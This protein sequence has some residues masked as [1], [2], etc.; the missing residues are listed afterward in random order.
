MPDVFQSS[1]E[2]PNVNHYCCD[3]K[4]SVIVYVIRCRCASEAMIG[5]C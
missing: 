4:V 2:P 3:N 5:C 1:E